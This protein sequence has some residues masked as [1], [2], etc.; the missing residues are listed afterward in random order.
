M[1][2]IRTQEDPKLTDDQLETAIERL[3]FK[4]LE[5]ADHIDFLRKEVS[6]RKKKGTN[7]TG[8]GPSLNC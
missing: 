5:L 2:I 3:E 1:K 8:G 7:Q 4:L 6:R